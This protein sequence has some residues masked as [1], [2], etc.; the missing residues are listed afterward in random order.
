M[1][2]LSAMFSLNVSLPSIYERVKKNDERG[3]EN[4][5]DNDDDVRD[6]TNEDDD[7]DDGRG[8]DHSN[9]TCFLHPKKYSGIS[10]L[11]SLVENFQDKYEHGN[12]PLVTT[13][14]LLEEK[15]RYR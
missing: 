8:G 9:N 12:G 4:Y 6:D 2:P 13:A 10:S 3:C 5:D 1:P 11:V 7:D 14:V 15:N